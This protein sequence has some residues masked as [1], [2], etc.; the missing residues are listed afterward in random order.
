[1]RT[2]AGSW[3]RSLSLIWLRICDSWLIVEIEDREERLALRAVLPMRL[4]A[5]GVPRRPQ[6]HLHVVIGLGVVRA[7][8]AGA[9]KVLRIGPDRI[10]QRHLRPHVFGAQRRRPHA[11]DQHGASRRADR[12]GRPGVGV[13]H[14][15]GRQFIEMRRDGIVVTIAAQVRPV[16]L[17]GDPEHVRAAC[18]L[19]CRTTRGEQQADS[20][21]SQAD[22]PTGHVV[23]LLWFA[24]K[25][26]NVGHAPWPEASSRPVMLPRKTRSAGRD[27][28]AG[29]V[30]RPVTAVTSA[31]L[32]S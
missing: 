26:G 27:C 31:V 11:G 8:I 23:I 19:V 2:S 24:S 12:R 1:M 10:G 25:P 18:G 20:D 17:A 5:A 32:S 21:R 28:R 9:A 22:V 30:G 16:V 3:M 4:A 13:A 29:R 6:I 15:A 7:V 14:A